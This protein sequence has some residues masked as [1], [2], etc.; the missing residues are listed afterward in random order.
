MSLVVGLASDIRELPCV[1]LVSNR[2]ANVVVNGF[3]S[4]ACLC[5]SQRTP[6]MAN[7]LPIPR[8]QTDRASLR[9]G[10]P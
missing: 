2:C 6:G 10:Q 1:V 3:D 9:R 7:Y 4:A 8:S 5:R